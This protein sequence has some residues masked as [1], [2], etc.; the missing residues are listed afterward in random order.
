M[1]RDEIYE[2]LAKVYLGKR[3]SAEQEKK[4]KSVNQSWLVINVTITAV[5]LLSTVYGFTAFLTRRA[6][7]NNQIFYELN[8]NLVKIPYDLN[9][10]FPS[11]KSFAISIPDKDVSKFSKLNLSMRGFNG[12]YP[13]VVKL[14]VSNLK[15]EKATYYIKNID[16]Q[17]HKVSIP[18]E[19]LNLTDWTTVSKVAFVLEAWNV[20]FRQGTVL[21]DDISFSN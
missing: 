19:Q 9:D 12:A 8:N 15:N 11:T 16:A 6:G 20:D 3:E 21:I 7:I 10:P 17:W 1:T 13:G 5:I 18:L 2:H 4:R 14:V